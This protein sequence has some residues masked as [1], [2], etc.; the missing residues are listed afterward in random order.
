MSY[1]HVSKLDDETAKN[2]EAIYSYSYK[3]WSNG[4]IEDKPTVVDVVKS[5]INGLYKNMKEA[6]EIK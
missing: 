1:N 3:K 6:G 2:L 5:L 4:E